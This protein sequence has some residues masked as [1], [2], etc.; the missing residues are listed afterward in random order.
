MTEYFVVR[1]MVTTASQQ[2]YEQGFAT[3]DEAKEYVARLKED[4]SRWPDKTPDIRCEILR[5]TFVETI[6]TSMF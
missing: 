6:E 3:I 2:W 1:W 4:E 5:F